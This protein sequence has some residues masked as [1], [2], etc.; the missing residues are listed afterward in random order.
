MPKELSVAPGPKRAQPH[1]S[2][3][4]AT[5][6]CGISVEYSDVLD[7][8]LRHDV[9]T[10]ADLIVAHSRRKSSIGNLLLGSVTRTRLLRYASCDVLVVAKTGLDAP[11]LA[12]GRCTGGPT[13]CSGRCEGMTWTG[14]S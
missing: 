3:T 9:Q 13:G 1:R 5:R 4:T 8:T 11:Q 2:S 7:M 14:M 10:N 12:A 6:W